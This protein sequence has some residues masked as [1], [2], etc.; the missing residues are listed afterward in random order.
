MSDADPRP[1][2][3]LCAHI[4]SKKLAMLGDEAENEVDLVGLDMFENYWCRR[5]WT[6]SGPDGGWVT[7]GRCH[8]AREC[9]ERRA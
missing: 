6:D 5:T 4:D 7:Y 8:P 9:Y 1:A 2:H 3:R